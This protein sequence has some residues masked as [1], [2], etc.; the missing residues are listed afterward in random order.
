MMAG[1]AKFLLDANVLMTAHRSYYA[2]DL[3]PGFWD[4]VKAGHTAGRIF[5]TH[6]VLDELHRG[7]DVLSHWVCDELPAGF[8]LNDSTAAVADEYAPMMRWVSSKDFLPAAKTKFASD[9]DGWLV[10]TSKHGDYCLVTQEA[11][12]DGAKARI[13]LPNLC[14]EFGVNYCNTFEMLRALS[15]CFR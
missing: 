9:A 1:G 11:R 8:F 2:F 3:C 13:P 14:E 6:R 4:S 15:C 12:Q 7:D 5:S 10:A